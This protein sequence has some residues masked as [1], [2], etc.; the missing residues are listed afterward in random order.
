MTEDRS[1]E[2]AST[3]ATYVRGGNA[4]TAPYRLAY[5]VDEA[6]RQANVC[7]D[8]IYQAIREGSLRAR[9]SGRRT[10]IL[11]ADLQV[12]LRNLPHLELRRPR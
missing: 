8:V 11:C 5:S 4:S 10:L 6:A 1:N 9:K 2:T 7:R 3:P 12:Y